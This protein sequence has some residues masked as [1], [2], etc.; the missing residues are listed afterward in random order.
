[1]KK[2][3]AFFR[4]GTA[5]EWMGRVLITL[6]IVPVILN[7][8]NREFMNR[9]S[10]NIETVAL[11]A[12]VWIGYA[13]FGYLYKKDIHVDVKFVENMLPPVGQKM[14]ELLRD[15][16]IFAFSV[17]MM[18]WGVKLCQSNISRMVTGTKIPFLF[19]YLS[20][21]I[22]FLS[23]AVRSFW[24]LISRFFKKDKEGGMGK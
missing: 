16:F 15:I 10:T 8:A 4:D 3:I 7:I 18:Y 1:M 13:E 2:I 23:G 22:G 11:F 24:A 20:I 17:F 5:E 21:V 12:Y 19:G 14:V 9:Y 6:V